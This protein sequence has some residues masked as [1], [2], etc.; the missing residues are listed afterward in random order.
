MT[1]APD[2]RVKLPTSLKMAAMLEIREMIFSGELRP[3]DKIDQDDVAERLG[4]SRLPVREAVIALDVEGVVE[5][6]PRR[7]AFVAAL[8]R[9][10]VRD[11]YGILGAVSGLAAARA[12]AR[13]TDEERTRMLDAVERMDCAEDA[14]ARERLNFQFHRVINLASGSRR[15]MSEIKALGAFAPIGF[16]ESHDHWHDTANRDHEAMAAAVSS[17]DEAGARSTTEEHFVRA[18]DRA[19]AML[20]E[21]GFWR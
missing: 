1:A 18:G 17:G 12:A 16:Y 8:S 3:G 13:M 15:L 4:V 7:G 10:D 5:L 20:S 19:V 14:A 21:R 2:S 9:D 6:A 11:H